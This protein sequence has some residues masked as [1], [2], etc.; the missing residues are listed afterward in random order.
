MQPMD[1]PEKLHDAVEHHAMPSWCGPSAT[2]HRHI[3][4]PA[5]TSRIELTRNVVAAQDLASPP[6]EHGAL[7]S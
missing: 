2:A 3:E 7:L 6:P 4:L 5:L 1:A